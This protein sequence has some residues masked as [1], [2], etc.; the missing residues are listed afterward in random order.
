MR[1]VSCAR[2]AASRKR[3]YDRA[4]DGET[5]T[6]IH[7]EDAAQALGLDWVDDHAKFQDPDA[8]RDSHR[9]SAYRIAELLGSLQGRGSRLPTSCAGSRSPYS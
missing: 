9:P 8:P 1:S 2:H 4:I 7:Q 5:V 6:L 3:S